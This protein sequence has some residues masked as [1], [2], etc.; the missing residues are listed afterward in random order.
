M[1]VNLGHKLCWW[2]CSNA[3]SHAHPFWQSIHNIC[4]M[5]LLLTSCAGCSKGAYL[6]V[7]QG[8]VQTHIFPLL[9]GMLH[10]LPNRYSGALD[11]ARLRDTVSGTAHL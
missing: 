9:L 10:D 1:H 6:S 7:A 4:M 3:S 2:L 11:E 8:S 5:S